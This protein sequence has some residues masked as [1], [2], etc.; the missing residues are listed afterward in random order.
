MSKDKAF[1]KFFTPQVKR[2]ARIYEMKQKGKTL[3][4]IGAK[5][6]LTKQRVSTIIKREEEKR[7][8]SQPIDKS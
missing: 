5:F 8:I 4:E 7:G 3:E 2:N 1:K 6:D